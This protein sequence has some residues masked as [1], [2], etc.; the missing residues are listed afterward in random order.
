MKSILLLISSFTFFLFTGRE[1][2]A[3][4][5]KEELQIL[6]QDIQKEME[7]KNIP[8]LFLSIIYQDS[9]IFQEGIGFADVENK[10]PVTDTT[11]FKMGSV[12]K[13]VG[14]LAILKL[15]EAGKL[16]LKDRISELLPEVAVQNP[17]E[18]QTPLQVVHLLEHTSGFDDVHLHAYNRTK[19]PQTTCPE[20]LEAHRNS[21]HSRWRPGTRH[22]Y[23]NVNYILLTC[24]VEKISGMEYQEFLRQNVFIPLK[25]ES[26]CFSHAPLSPG[27]ATGYKKEGGKIVQE[28]Q[29]IGKTGLGGDFLANANDMT[30]LLK[31]FLQPKDYSKN[32]LPPSF[33]NRMEQ[34]HTTLA[35]ASGVHDFY[36]LGNT[37]GHGTGK[38]PFR[39]HGGSVPGFTSYYGY[40]RQAKIGYAIAINNGGGLF[41]LRQL[42]YNFLIKHTDVPDQAEDSIALDPEKIRFFLGHYSFAA[43]K[44]EIEA[45]IDRLS[46]VELFMKENNLYLEKNG[47]P[48]RLVRVKDN[49]YRYASINTPTISLTYDAEGKPVIATI[50]EYFEQS[51]ALRIRALRYSIFVS[52]MVCLSF[53]P[54]FSIIAVYRGVKGKFPFRSIKM[55]S[56]PLLA[57]ISAIFSLGAAVY[58]AGFNR[59]LIGSVHFLE[60]VVFLGSIFFAIASILTAF[61]ALK[62]LK[63][64]KF[65]WVNLYLLALGLSL[66]ILTTFLTYNN[67]IGFR[68][69]NY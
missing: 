18:N 37:L 13:S 20:M 68:F 51:S 60:I 21:L 17:W 40:N 58:L 64:Q 67:I 26:A 30:Q 69:W 16:N 42:V 22:V 57:E 56:W 6:L 24:L 45:F 38:V 27:Q 11:L 5:G 14:A 33:I 29:S 50:N 62:K 65:S 48:S 31:L 47:N 49:V 12:S 19:S 32:F 59:D 10:V 34:T 61:V 35:A 55:F 23:S 15:A 66:L 63:N 2:L 43:P 53:L 54:F 44:S 41:P 52:L 3:Q 36:G 8:G 28:H 7:R 9:V 1:A 25:M 39:G 4:P 46:S